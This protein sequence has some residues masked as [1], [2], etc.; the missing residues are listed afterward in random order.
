MLSNG[1]LAQ[2]V[3]IKRGGWGEEREPRPGTLVLQERDPRGGTLVLASQEKGLGK[4]GRGSGRRGK[5][6]N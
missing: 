6:G 1:L 3:V 5:E 4:V 2:P